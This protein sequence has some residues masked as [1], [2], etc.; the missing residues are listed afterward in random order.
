[1]I[2]HS[3][4]PTHIFFAKTVRSIYAT[5]SK[6]KGVALALSLAHLLER[7]REMSRCM[8][9]ALPFVAMVLAVL[10]QVT[11]LTVGKMAMSRGLNF[12]ILAV[13]G[14]LLSTLI[15][16]PSAFIFSRYLCIYV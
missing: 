5:I 9:K 15:S 3:H 12:F 13:Y 14:D 6:N 7:E 1:M 4:T 11:N 2:Q 16:L 8:E 10:G